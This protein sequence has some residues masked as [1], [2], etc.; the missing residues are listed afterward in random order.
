MSG[1]AATP[2]FRL[3][4]SPDAAASIERVGPGEPTRVGKGRTP[5]ELARLAGLLF[6]VCAIAQ[7]AAALHACE[8]AAGVELPK[9]Q[10]AARDTLVLAEAIG[11]CVWRSALMWPLL[12]NKAVNPSPA[13]AARQAL[14]H[15]Q[16]SLFAGPWQSPGGAPLAIDPD[17]LAS[18]V[19][20]LAGLADRSDIDEV[21][22]SAAHYTLAGAL[23]ATPLH[24]AIFDGATRPLG[25]R[26]E[27]S[28]RSLLSPAAPPRSLADWFSAQADHA[29]SLAV[30]LKARSQAVDLS[31]AVRFPDRTSGIGLGLSMTA[32]GRLRHIVELE[33]GRVV[34]WNVAAPTDW[35]LAPQGLLKAL[36]DS[37]VPRG[38][39]MAAK[40]II[41]A[42]DPCLPCKVVEAAAHA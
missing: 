24:E 21:A 8:T 37:L 11:G 18:A 3:V 32:R 22:R 39:L 15:I 20:T 38:D 19:D 29:R 25:G 4:L 30:A 31:G 42:T 33:N 36:C 26:L 17:G 12:V 16:A 2:G 34:N 40:W 35:N 6:P 5:R 10:A 23:A 13:Q 7:T 41:A 28:P 1:T 14:K 27:E 9:G